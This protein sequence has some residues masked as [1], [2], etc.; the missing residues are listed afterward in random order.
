MRELEV[1]GLYLAADVANRLVRTVLSP[2]SLTTVLMYGCEYPL[3][4]IETIS[5]SISSLTFENPFRAR[6]T[7][8]RVKSGTKLSQILRENTSLKE[9]KLHIPL[10]EKEVKD[11]IAS[12]RDNHSLVRLELSGRYHSQYFSESEKEVMDSRISLANPYFR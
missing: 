8:L 2:S 6:D 4:G 10:D 7:S 9:L 12:L 11:I 1:G 5:T 3:D